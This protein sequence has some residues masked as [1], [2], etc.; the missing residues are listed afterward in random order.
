MNKVSFALLIHSHQ[1]VGNFDHVME[2][3]YRKSYGPFLQALVRHP[4]IRLSL[5]FSGILLEWIGKEHPEYFHQLR[6]LVTRGQVELVGGGYYEPILAVIPDADKHAQI[7]KLAD[8]LHRHFGSNVR[9]AWVA[10]RIW[11]PTLPRPLVEAGVDYV[12]LDDTHF[13]AAGLEPD[14]LR[15]SYISEEDGFAI[16]LVPSLKALR[17]TIP[18]REPAQTLEILREGVG[19]PDALFAMGDDGEKFGVWPGTYDYVFKNG[20]MERFFDAIEGSESWLET[21]TVSDYLRTHPPL[22]RIYLPTASYAEMME[23]SLP[24]KASADFK[25][26]LEES[27]HIP[28]GGRFQRFLRGGMWRNF[29]SKYPESNQMQK[30]VLRLSHHL[31]QAYA[32]AEMATEKADLIC[33]ARAHLMAAQCNDAYWHGIFGGLYA[34]HLRSASLRHLIEAESLVDQVESR[35]ADAKPRIESTDFD[36]DGHEEILVHQGVGGMIVRPAD[37]GTVSSLRFKP[38]KVELINSLMRRPEAYHAMVRKQVSSQASPREGPAS[39]HDL[40]LSKE[41]HLD[42]LLRYDRYARHGFRTYLFPGTKSWQDYD[43]LHLDENIDLAGGDWKTFPIRS[44]AAAVELRRTVQVQTHEC[45]MLVDAVKTLTSTVEGSTW[46]VDCRS[47]FSTDR[48]CSADLADG[49]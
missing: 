2:E 36:A 22:G 42:A 41:A 40:T 21:T 31:Q 10:E 5:H 43:Y 48:S 12:V 14:Q 27:E 34:P 45:E 28:N 11:E 17:Y 25:S 24:A 6:G 39:I 18:F 26:C 49:P 32:P 1:P 20:W 44:G 47:S 15:G 35:D 19:R 9:G 37:G 29:L 16:R 33:A 8:Y 23:W 46:R 7:R 38:A 3:A 30:Q 4:R 13:L